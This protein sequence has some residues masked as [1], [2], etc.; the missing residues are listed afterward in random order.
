MKI[1]DDGSIVFENPVE[2]ADWRDADEEGRVP[3]E[4][5]ACH[6]YCNVGNMAA[7]ARRFQ[8][9]IYV[10]KKLTQQAWWQELS[11]RIQSESKTSIDAGFTR[12]VEKGLRAMEDRLDNGEIEFVKEGPDGEK[13]VVRKPLRAIDIARITDMAFMKRQ[14]IRN[15]PT[16]IP[17][18]TQAIT[19]L[20][21]KLRALGRK[22]PSL[23]D[24]PTEG[25]RSEGPTEGEQSGE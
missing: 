8:T 6:F 3:W 17:G 4:V 5:A 23:L 20:A 13:E 12:L 21:T 25:L 18:A 2:E 7:T 10:I 19:M 22:D 14:L 1:M 15:Q 16:D 11:T 24:A 9:S